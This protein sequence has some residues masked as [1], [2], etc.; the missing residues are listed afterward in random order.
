MYRLHQLAVVTLHKTRYLF[1]IV[2]RLERVADHNGVEVKDSILNLGVYKG[3]ELIV[4]G[5]PFLGANKC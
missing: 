3:T 5:L 1:L 4:R 2:L